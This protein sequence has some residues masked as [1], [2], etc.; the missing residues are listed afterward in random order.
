[1][2]KISVPI[3]SLLPTAIKRHAWPLVVAASLGFCCEGVGASEPVP[4]DSGGTLVHPCYSHTT[5]R[6]NDGRVLLVAGE[7]QFAGDNTACMWAVR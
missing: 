3:S 1:M 2:K 4:A 5:T 6:L 7:D